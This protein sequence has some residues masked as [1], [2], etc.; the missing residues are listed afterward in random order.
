MEFPGDAITNISAINGFSVIYWRIYTEETSINTQAS[1]TVAT[2]G[3]N[4]LKLLSR[5]K[6]LE[7]KLRSL[8]C[9]VSCYPRRLGLWVFSSTPGF[10]SL[11][12]L[13]QDPTNKDSKEQ[14]KLSIGGSFLKVSASGSIT[15]A[16]LIR[17]LSTDPSSVAGGSSNQSRTPG[18]APNG[19]RTGDAHSNS[20]AIYAS[21]V[22]AVAG[23]ISLQL[24]RR[25]NAIPLGARTL[26]TS[27]D[28][29]FFDDPNIANEDADSLP[30]LTTL[31]IEVSPVGKIIVSLHTVY[32]DGIS[33]LGDPGLMEV[34]LTD[35][36][37]NM[38]VWL[39]P[40]GTVARLITVNTEQS[41]V[42]AARQTKNDANSR[43]ITETKQR[44]WKDSVVEWMNNVGLP[45]KCPEEEQ[46]VEVEVS[47]PFYARLAADYLRQMDDSQSSSPLKRILW[48]SSYCFR[49]AKSASTTLVDEIDLLVTESDDP[50]HFAENWLGTAGTRQGKPAAASSILQ[51]IPQTKDLSTPRVDF[52]EHIESL[53]RVAQYPDLQS[54]STVYPTPP[55]GAL[56]SAMNQAA[57]DPFGADGHEMSMS[58]ISAD[59]SIA[60]RDQMVKAFGGNA[61]SGLKNELGVAT[62]LY[63]THGD[64]DLFGDIN[65]KDFGPKGI[66]DADFNFFDDP[67]IDD[68]EPAKPDVEPVQ[69]T[70]QQSLP[71]VT[72]ARSPTEDNFGEKT[73]DEIATQP[74]NIDTQSNDEP[75]AILSVDTNQT[76]QTNQMNQTQNITSDE[77]AWSLSKQAISPPLSPVEVKRILF[78]AKNTNERNEGAKKDTKYVDVDPDKKPSRYNSIS[79]QQGLTMSDQ[80]YANSG[81]FFFTAQ[82]DKPPTASFASETPEIPTVGFPRGRKQRFTYPNDGRTNG[83]HQSPPMQFLPRSASVSSSDTSFDS[84]DDDGERGVSP[85][86]L[87]NLKRKRPLSEAERSTTSSLE[88]LSIASEIDSQLAKEDSSV[89]L[90]NFFSVFTDWSLAGCFSIRQNQYSPVL[91]RK[92]DQVQLAQLMVDQLTQSSL[93]HNIDGSKPAPDLEDDTVSLH[94][95]FD[96]TTLGDSERLDLRTLVSMH[97]NIQASVETSVSRMNIQ[98]KDIKGS[99]MRLPPPHL[100]IHRGRDFIEVLPSS[101]SFWETFGLEPANGQKDVSSYCIY[102]HYSAEGADTFVTRLGL[103]YSSCNLGKHVRGDK[104][105]AFENGMGMWNIAKGDGSYVRT[106]QALKN[107]CEGLGSA[108]SK[109]P[110]VRENF[111]I[112]VINPFTHGAAFADICSAFLHL[113]HKYIGDVDKN[114][115]KSQMNELVLQIVPMSFVSSP[116]SIAVPTQLQCLSLA[117]EVYSRCPPKVANS[118]I[119]NY[120]PPV[121]LADNVPK[122]LHFKV[123][124]ERIS[125]FQEGRC[126]HLAV[127]RSVDQRWISAAWSDSSGSCQ[128]L[129]SYCVRV[130]GSNVN[131]ILSEVRQEIWETTKDIMDRTQT[132]SKIFLVRTEPID[133]EE[134]EA[135]T[136]LAERYNQSKA[137]PVE[138]TLFSVSVAPGI[139]LE[140]PTTQIQ[141]NMINPS[142]S[143]PVTTPYGGVSSPDQFGVGTPAS[144][145]QAAFAAATPTEV[146]GLIEPDS[147]TVLIDAQDESWAVILSH[148]LSNSAFMTEYKP[149]LISGYLLRRRGGID[150]QGVATMS[151]N[152][153][154]T[155]RPPGT[156][157][158][159]LREALASYRDLGTLARAKG[160]F[161]VQNNTLPWHIATA[162]KGQE[163]LSYVL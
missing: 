153:V 141:A 105:K 49:R 81:H 65:D 42:F 122:N 57:S 104:S 127:S 26:F 61:A 84:S 114:N 95:S 18:T 58:Q 89:F 46:W 109:A 7:I 51:Q 143:T 103:L 4:I 60:R 134:I 69:E 72:E 151:V 99:I 10:E 90:G 48:P 87:T 5:L 91:I 126:L 97:D 140:L 118:R 37:P 53:A 107:L 147:D 67:E 85:I 158:A 121:L 19:S 14:D 16:D 110:S 82:K 75:K 112:Y 132:R 34:N 136:G 94:T 152:L 35:V 155:P 116:T 71:E 83:A 25:F 63:D 76:N 119:T 123:T 86:R 30:A 131:R 100:R 117:L 56:A 44:F 120:A 55:D 3:Y 73:Q 135:W 68:F 38:D 146:S 145:N 62:G 40:N 139:R 47:E 149:A 74:I 88:R 125:P 6:D 70:R 115:A 24:I 15:A 98:R 133:Q 29:S 160:T 1:E 124:S 66:T 138:L 111:V 45:V 106:M 102:P 54:A 137:I 21:F 43:Q 150:S 157:E 64:E 162:V 27:I 129:M 79:F 36:R 77:K 22:S 80:K 108:L 11:H 78:S 148:R 2:N 159:V 128:I 92:D 93:S 20:V 33:R 23:V 28:R 52:S 142:S 9:L 59:G 13:T 17:S 101:I 156:H 50:V 144:G 154:H 39:A 161:A 96:D 130:R 113:L 32:Q 8:N 31:R 163:F 12:P 41:T